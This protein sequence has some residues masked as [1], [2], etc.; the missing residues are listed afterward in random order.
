[1]GTFGGHLQSP[2][3]R[4]HA[5]VPPVTSTSAHIIDVLFGF[6]T[7]VALPG[8]SGH[9]AAYVASVKTAHHASAP[10][11]PALCP[12]PSPACQACCSRLL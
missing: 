4:A 3:R 2:P 8:S 10:G 9:A 7:R 6:L 11:R 12:L 1:M 5:Q